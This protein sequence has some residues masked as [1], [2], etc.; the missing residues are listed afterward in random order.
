[1]ILTKL[2]ECQKSFEGLKIIVSTRQPHLLQD[3]VQEFGIEAD[4]DNIKV[5]RECDL[6]FL[7]SLPFQAEE[8]LKEIRDTVISRH[9]EIGLNKAMSKPLFVSTLAAVG[10]PKLKLLLTQEALFVRTNVDV[11]LIKIQVLK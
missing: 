8:I 11:G 5:A 3:F 2:I 9:Y 10:V 1:M 4:Y 7:C 6:I